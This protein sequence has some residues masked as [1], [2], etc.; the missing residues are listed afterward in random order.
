MG[1]NYHLGKP[2][3]VAH[4][5]S[6]NPASR[7]KPVPKM[8]PELAKEFAL[9]NLLLVLEGTVAQLE[10]QPTLDGNIKEAQKGHPSIEGIKKKMNLGKAPKFI[11]DEKGIL[12]YRDRL[13]VPE[14]GRAHV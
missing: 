4:A 11:I 8:R 2:N 10:V 9:L 1:I 12:W 7:K 5:L 14:I 6:R 13:C 3:V